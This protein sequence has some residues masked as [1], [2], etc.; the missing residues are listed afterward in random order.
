M[1]NKSSK[2]EIG[3]SD[4]RVPPMKNGSFLRLLSS[5]RAKE[6]DFY[7]LLRVA[8]GVAYACES[9]C[10]F[11]CGYHACYVCVLECVHMCRTLSVCGFGTEYHCVCV[12][13]CICVL[14]CDFFCLC[15]C[16][17]EEL[18]VMHD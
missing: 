10:L 15:A 11:L 4:L 1:L 8:H 13:S 17:K 7:K 5:M 12:C 6:V 14:K 3:D 18:G 2:R 9:N 16:V